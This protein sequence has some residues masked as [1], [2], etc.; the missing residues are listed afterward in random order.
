MRAYGGAGGG[1]G[2]GRVIIYLSL[3][4]HHQNDSCINTYPQQKPFIS[5]RRFVS[6]KI[7]GPKISVGLNMF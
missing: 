3:R 6:G 2:G 1:G 4:C 5:I 7:R